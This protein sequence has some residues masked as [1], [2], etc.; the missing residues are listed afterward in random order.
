MIFD[1]GRKYVEMDAETG[2]LKKYSIDGVD[3][4][5]DDFELVAFD[6]NSDPWAMGKDQVSRL[7]TN[8]QSFILSKT[9]SGVFEK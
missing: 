9:P 1:N 3:Y 2:L 6:D 8:E 4:V 7:E 5:K